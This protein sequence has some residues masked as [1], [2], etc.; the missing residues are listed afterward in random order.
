M[1]LLIS[2]F[3]L[4]IGATLR[5]T[6]DDVMSGN[7]IVTL[8]FKTQP[9]KSDMAVSEL[10]KLFESVSKEPH[11]VS[12]KLHVDPNDNKNILLYEEWESAEYYQTDH[13]K[14]PHLEAF[15]AASQEFL[16]GPPEIA[17]W[18]MEGE[19]K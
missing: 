9:E 5:G 3:C 15:M 13:M 11:F 7:A 4:L 19:F 2:A 12:I 14:T 17:F 1:T 6:T 18:T 10:K 16:A 8:K